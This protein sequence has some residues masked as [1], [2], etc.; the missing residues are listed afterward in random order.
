MFSRCLAGEQCHVRIYHD[1]DKFMKGYFRLSTDNLPTFEE[2]IS[3]IIPFF[4]DYEA[5]RHSSILD[6]RVQESCPDYRNNWPGRFLFIADR[7]AAACASHF[8]LASSL[9]SKL[10]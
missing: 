5:A 2:P 4:D 9:E 1:A 3:L 8:G 10:G 7:S 6:E